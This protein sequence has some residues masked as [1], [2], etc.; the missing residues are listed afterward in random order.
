[1][2]KIL[3]ED[4]YNDTYGRLRMFEA[5]KLRHKNDTK[6]HIPSQRTIYR[7]M[8]TLGLIHH[9]KRNPHGITKADR[10]ARKSDDL[11]KRDF[12]SEK[13]LEKCITD[14]TELKAKNGKLYVSAIFDCFD[15]AVLGLSLD[16]YMKAT[17]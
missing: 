8:K 2:Q 5:I 17:L 6:F 11:L 15:S 3:A 12:Y 1:M 14:I 13:P 7:I 16:I 9:P 10:E 4:L